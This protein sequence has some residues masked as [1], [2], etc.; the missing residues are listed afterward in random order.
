MIHTGSLPKEKMFAALCE[1]LMVQE[2]ME[3]VVW[4]PYFKNNAKF[5]DTIKHLLA[6]EKNPAKIIK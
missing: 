4:Y 5:K 6:E 2:T 1:L 3:H